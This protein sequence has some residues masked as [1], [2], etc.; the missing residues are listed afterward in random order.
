MLGRLPLPRRACKAL[1]SSTIAASHAR[2]VH[3]VVLFTITDA[4]I[5]RNQG[6]ERVIG[7]LLGSIS[8]GVVEV[9]N[10]YAVPHSE[11]NEQVG[12]RPS[13]R[14]GRQAALAAFRSRCLFSY[15]TLWTVVRSSSNGTGP[16]ALT[17]PPI[18]ATTCQPL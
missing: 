10:C 11:S 7:T 14:W 8:D 13:G 2:R 3:P 1:T 4:F 16:K 15:L 9:K 12:G 17:Q 6:Q 18:C 5:R